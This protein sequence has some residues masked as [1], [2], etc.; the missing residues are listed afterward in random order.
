MFRTKKTKIPYSLEHNKA[1]YSALIDLIRSFGSVEGEILAGLQ[2]D[3]TEDLSPIANNFS[4]V[5]DFLANKDDSVTREEC[6]DMYF[7]LLRIRAAADYIQS[8]EQTEDP[9]K[10]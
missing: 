4:R 2:T 3:L 7:L 10:H 1:L 5:V 9:I 6:L 8:E